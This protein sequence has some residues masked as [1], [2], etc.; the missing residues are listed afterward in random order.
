MGSTSDLAGRKG[1]D[2]S[3]AAYGGSG[4][5][6]TKEGRGD[7]RCPSATEAKQLGSNE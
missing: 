1:H 2:T 3:Y 7:A 6:H 5:E 4:D